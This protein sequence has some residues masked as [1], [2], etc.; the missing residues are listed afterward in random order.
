MNA[1]LFVLLCMITYTFI[2]VATY[3]ISAYILFKKERA[4]LS[5]ETFAEWLKD[6]DPDTHDCNAE[7]PVLLGV[8]WVL[9]LVVAIIYGIGWCL[10]TVFSW[11]FKKIFNVK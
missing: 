3:W 4:K 6:I 5:K 9:T 7:A 2:A 1:F 11:P 10:I 8:F